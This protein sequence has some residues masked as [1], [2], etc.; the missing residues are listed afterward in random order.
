MCIIFF[1]PQPQEVGYITVLLTDEGTK[2]QRCKSPAHSQ[3]SGSAGVWILG[4]DPRA[5]YSQ[6]FI[7][8]ICEYLMAPASVEFMVYGNDRHRTSSYK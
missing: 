5:P 3:L 4:S 2:S 7:Q 1:N 8:Q 6:S